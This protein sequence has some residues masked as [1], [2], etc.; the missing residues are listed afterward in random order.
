MTGII[1]SLLQ[2]HTQHKGYPADI[3]TQF[4]QGYSKSLW[5]FPRSL[6][7]LVILQSDHISSFLHLTVLSEYW[8]GSIFNACSHSILKW[9]P[10]DYFHE[11]DFYS[12][13][14]WLFKLFL[15]PNLCGAIRACKE[16][17]KEIKPPLFHQ[18]TNIYL[19]ILQT[20]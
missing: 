16:I 17:F 1:M 12:G 9:K 2:T 19:H 15:S 11:E 7:C 14:L 20:F 4:K 8:Q 13:I 10:I 3:L 6:M 5:L 18:K